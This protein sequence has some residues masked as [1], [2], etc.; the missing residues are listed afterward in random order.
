MIAK[1]KRNC[2]GFDDFKA[3]F[4]RILVSKGIA[5][6]GG[7]GGG[8]GKRSGARSK[9]GKFFKITTWAKL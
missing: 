4:S 7:G 6:G 1:S 9:M 8:G 2:R 5:D 3:I